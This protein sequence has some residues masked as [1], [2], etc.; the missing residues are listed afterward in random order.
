MVAAKFGADLEKNLQLLKERLGEG[1]DIIWRN[2]TIGA[3]GARG[4][5]LY[6]DGLTDKTTLQE[7]VL[8]PLVILSTDYPAGREFRG[9]FGLEKVMDHLLSAGGVKREEDVNKAVTALLAGDT[10]VLLQNCSHCLIVSTRG[11][12]AR[13]ITEPATE[14][15]I[16]GP[17]DG[18][19]ETLM[20]NIALVRRRIRDDRLVVDLRQLGVRSQTDVAVMYIKDLAPPELVEEVNRRLDKINLDALIEAGYVEQLIE[21]NL[22]SPFPQLQ[23]TERPDKV[24]GGLLEGRI[25]ILVD[26][27]PFALLLPATLPVLYQSPEDYYERWQVASFARFLRFIASFFSVLTPAAYIAITSYHPGMLPTK[28]AMAIASSRGGVPFPAFV[29]AALMEISFELLREAG[30]RLPRAI[31]QTI[32]IVGGLVIGNA[33]VQAGIASPIMIIIVAITAIASF[34]IPHYNVAAGLRL[35]RFPLMV[36]AALLGMYGV[37]LGFILL[38]IHFVR[39]KSFGVVYIQPA[40]PFNLRDWKDVI[41]RLPW[42]AMKLRP[43]TFNARDEV[44]MGD[45]P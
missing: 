27:S 45:K 43:S 16:R 13:S 2:F 33:A 5:L 41:F 38:N 7:Q 9:T 6:V 4:A 10:L 37:I 15:L 20:V 19:V 12:S 34:A 28:L 36:A 39:L 21:D 29:E 1:K 40:V 3:S 25:A 42:Q 31:G 24:V 11:W 18:F 44:R 17:R 30:A 22:W 32:S 8:K 26:N 14:A 23:H 35:M